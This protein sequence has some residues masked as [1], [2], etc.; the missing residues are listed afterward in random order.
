[1]KGDSVEKMNIAQP[2]HLNPSGGGVVWRGRGGGSCSLG[3]SLL[4]RFLSTQ[5]LLFQ[6]HYPWSPDGQR[7]TEGRRD[8]EREG[9]RDTEREGQRDTQREGQRDTHRERQR[10]RDT[11]R[12][13][14]GRWEVLSHSQAA[15]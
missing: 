2:G 1:M 4:N 10:E 13:G 7:E 8:T 15:D 11:E 12:E 5:Q 9:Q 3:R 6:Q 14:G